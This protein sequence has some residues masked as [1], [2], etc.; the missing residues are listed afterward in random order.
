MV[1]SQGNST[2]QD[3]GRY[4]Y[5]RARR[6]SLLDLPTIRRIETDPNATKEAAIV[7]GVVAIASA[8]GGAD[9]AGGGIL[10]G[11]LGAFLTWLIMSGMTYFLGT[12]VFGTPTTRVTME[13]LLRTL[14]YAQAPRTLALL[15]FL[16][17]FG[18]MFVL[19][20]GLWAFV[21]SIVAIRETL[22]L[23]TTRAV[24]I[25]IAAALTTALLVGTL[26]ILF[27]ADIGTGVFL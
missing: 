11:L 19:A 14:G 27:S 1:A 6:V 24:L 21:A 12:N 2:F 13:S 10:V 23:S 5:E 4:I 22:R 18:W 26:S 16:P 7:V 9:D 17:L 8:I 15:G 3:T 25:A 20:G